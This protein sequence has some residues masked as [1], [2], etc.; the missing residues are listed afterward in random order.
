VKSNAEFLRILLVHPRSPDTFWSFKHA[1][2]FISEKVFIQPLGLLTVAALLPRTWK[3]R[4]VDLNMDILKDEDIQWADYVFLGAM[5]V[6]QVSVREIIT[7][8]KAQ[9]KKIVAG[10]PL[11]TI[12]PD[13]FQEID[14]LILQEAEATLPAFIEDLKAGE[15]K[16]VYTSTEWPDITSSPIPQWDLLDFRNYAVMCIQYSRGCPFDCDF[17]D[18]ALLNG[19]KPRVKTAAQVLGELETLYQKG[20]RG[21]VLF[22]DDNFIGKPRKLKEDFL[23]ALINWM[24]KKQY[25]FRFLTQA[26]IN[27]AD[28]EEL[29]KLM[30]RAGFDSVFVGIETPEEKSLYECNKVLNKN[31]DLIAAVKEMQRFG[32]EVAGGFIIGFDSDPPAIFQKQIDFI[33]ESGIITAMI[34]LLNAPKGTKLYERL[35]QEGRLIGEWTGNMT[36]FSLNFFPKMGYQTLIEG[37]KYVVTTI[38]SPRN[39]YRRLITFLKNYRPLNKGRHALQLSH[40]KAFLY[41]I[42]SLGIRGKGRFYYW[43]T[44]LWTILRRPELFPL[45]VRLAIYGYHFRKVFETQTPKSEDFPH[46][47]NPTPSLLQEGC[48]R[49]VSRGRKQT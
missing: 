15:P 22:A 43:K 9:S 7:K 24:E 36:D 14:H 28:D 29:M 20:W 33:Q 8:V 46:L 40:I 26:T 27:L 12:N 44:L 19:R 35:R 32:L 42:W 41:S 10:G 17:C 13:R 2:K 34:G 21:T 30:A 45:C 37:Y 25:P 48:E 31:R 23:P 11:F 4:L 47:A 5:E 49:S 3:L 39:F 6:Q 38:Y 1:L 18:I 16:S